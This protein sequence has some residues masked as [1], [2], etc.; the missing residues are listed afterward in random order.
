MTESYIETGEG[1]TT[2]VGPDATHL[3][4]AMTLRSAMNL[5]IKVK[6]QV[7]RA[8]TPKNML[9]TASRFT[10]KTYKRGQLKQAAADLHVWI[11]AMKSAMPIVNQPPTN[12]E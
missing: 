6:V 9:L 2:F 4:A 10:G 11:E 5:Y 3:F 1:H 8:Y 12:G 7:N